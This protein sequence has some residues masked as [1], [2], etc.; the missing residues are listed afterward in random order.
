VNDVE[1]GSPP[2]SGRNDETE[3]DEDDEE[4]E[5]GEDGDYGFTGFDHE[6]D[7]LDAEKLDEYVAS[8]MKEI[9]RRARY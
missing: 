2:D 7:R 1:V 6:A 3:G 8:C 5:G 9:T 4:D